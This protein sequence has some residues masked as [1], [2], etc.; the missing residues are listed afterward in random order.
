M[1]KV[2]NTMGV[3][4][5]CSRN[6]VYTVDALK[7]FIILLEK[8]GFNMLMLYTEDT[9]EIPEEPY[10]GYFRGRY[11]QAE[12]KEIDAFAK[13]HGV[14]LVPAIQTLAHL[15]RLKYHRKYEGMFDCNDILNLADERT[16]DLI[17]KMFK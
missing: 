8:M 17:D 11:T 6:A 1:E 16:Y 14:E 7:R 3:M 5:D 4:V 12:I 2:F 13:E 15:A 10:F 9:F